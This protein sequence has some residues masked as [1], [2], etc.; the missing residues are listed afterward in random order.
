MGVELVE[1]QKLSNVV[2][3]NN[4]LEGVNTI[5]VCPSCS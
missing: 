3:Y 5:T 4:V 2:I 1:R